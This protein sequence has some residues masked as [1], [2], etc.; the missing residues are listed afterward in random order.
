MPVKN[1]AYSARSALPLGHQVCSPLSR[2][3][4][5]RLVPS[6]SRLL[7]LFLSL[8][9]S[10]P[11]C[12]SSPRRGAGGAWPSP[13]EDRADAGEE[14]GILSEVGASRRQQCPVRRRPL[15][16][17][18]ISSERVFIIGTSG[19]PVRNEY[20]SGFPIGNECSS[21]FPIGYKYATGFHI[22]N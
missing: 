6:F 21:G 10:R 15:S 22:G 1:Q 9:L 11:A 16:G 17:F 20:S 2:N 18:G 13:G 12:Q 7:S 19:F 3:N 14:P 4:C 8:P 5:L